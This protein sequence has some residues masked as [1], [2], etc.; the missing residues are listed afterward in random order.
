M[1][2]VVP[3]SAFVLLWSSG[4]IISEIGLQHGSPFG[5]LILR[6]GLALAVLTLA[7]ILNR[8]LLPARGSRSR[9]AF[10]G[11]AIAGVYSVC[12]LLA[13]DHGVTPGALATILGI[14]PILTMLITERKVGP[15]RLLGLLL[16]LGG[17]AMVVGDGLAAMRFEPV[18]LL[19]ALLGLMGITFGSIAQKRETQAPWV[20]LPM[21]YAVGLLAVCCAATASGTHSLWPATWDTSFVLSGVWLGLVIS[22]GTTF[23]LYRLIARGNL[24]N[25]T[26][27]FYLVPG[28][29]AAMDWAVLGHPMSILAMGGLVLIMVGLCVVFRAD[30]P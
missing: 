11:F 24:V 28:V 26:S 10:I 23:L 6:Y 21:Q 17:L 5:L 12:Y 20:V 29:T 7:A 3:T 9:V 16:A 15:M 19:F 8:Q 2:A 30:R 13:M 22:V 14:Q 1:S 18:G 25:V 27:L 4:A